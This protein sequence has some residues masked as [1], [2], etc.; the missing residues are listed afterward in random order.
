MKTRMFSSLAIATIT[1]L[2]VSAGTV[3]AQDSTATATATDPAAPPLSYGVAPVV[4]L[5][6]AKVADDIIVRYVQ[7]SGT[8][9]ALKAPEIVYLKQ[10]G[11]SDAVLNAMLYQRERLTGSTEPGVSSATAI[12]TAPAPAAATAT[13]A[14][15]VIVQPVAAPLVVPMVACAEP[16][17]SS[18]Y[19]I[20]DTQTARYNGWYGSYPYGPHYHG[21]YGNGYE[22]S[23]AYPAVSVVHIGT[24]YGGGSYGSGRSHMHHY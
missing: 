13:P 17:S 9:Y 16:V 8:I 5:A 19:V 11:V 1:T 21:R 3:S 6:Q 7:N 2:A 20:P 23:Y 4:E 10:Q 18:V 12:A 22:V 24:S 15:T 14:P